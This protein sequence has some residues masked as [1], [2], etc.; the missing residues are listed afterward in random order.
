MKAK[1][2]L[3]SA[4]VLL[5]VLSALGLWQARRGGT[6]RMKTRATPPSSGLASR[7][8]AKTDS[9]DAIHIYQ[10]PEEAPSWSIAYGNEFWR[11][12]DAKPDPIPAQPHPSIDLSDVIER[13]SHALTADRPGTLPTVQART[14]AATVDGAG[15]RFAPYHPPGS[16]AGASAGASSAVR[17]T[18]SE[19]KGKEQRLS[20]LATRTP[21]TPE[22][23]DLLMTGLSALAAE[24]AEAQAIE[25]KSADSQRDGAHR[26]DSGW[27]PQREPETEAAFQTVSVRQENHELY[28]ASASS[29]KWAVLGNTAQA[30][31]DPASGLVEHFECGGQGVAVTWVL[32]R[33]LA[34]QGPLVVEARLTG[35]AYAGQTPAGHHFADRTGTAR[36]RVGN[37]TVIDAAGATW[38]VGMQ[39]RDDSLRITVPS[40]ILAQASYPLAIDPLVAPEF[41]MDTPIVVPAPAAQQNPAVAANA[42]NFFVAWEDQRSA[43]AAGA[44]IFG[45]R[46]T[47][48]GIISDPNGIAISP[49]GA[50]TP[51]V[52]ANG[53]G[54]LVV[55]ADGRN[56]ATKGIDIFGARVNSAGRVVDAG[57]LP[58]CTAAGDQLSPA[59]TADGSDSFVVWQD[60]RNV[61][62]AP[63]IYGARVT[64]GGVVSDPNG[65]PISATLGVQATPAVAFNGTNFLV[66]WA[67]QRGIGD[68][69]TY[70]ARVSKTGQVLETAGIPISTVA[71]GEFF[72]KVAAK[73]TNFLVVWEEHRNA[74][75]GFVDIY[76]AR[77]SGAGMVLDRGGFP[78]GSGSGDRFTPTVAAGLTDYLVVW[79]DSRNLGT[80]GQDIYGARV[81][82]GGVVSDAS[83]IPISTAANDEST[84]VLSFNGSQY[85]VA[86]SDQRNFD[87]TDFDVYGAFVTAAGKVATAAGFAISTGSSD[88]QRPAVAANG[89]SYL[90]VWQDYRNS[91]TSGADLYG[92]RVSAAGAVLD[93]SAIPISTAAAD[94]VMP[95]V[96]ARRGDYLVVW[97]DYRNAGTTGA[98]IYG[99]LVTTAGVVLNPGGIGIGVANADQLA[100]AVAGA[101]TNYLVVWHD[102]R[103][104]A[105]S[106]LDI[107]GSRV[108][109]SAA[110]QD[111]SGLALCTVPGA[112]YGAAVAFNGTNF[113]VV[114]S[115]ERNLGVTGVDV[116]GRRVTPA[117]ALLDSPNIAITQ[118]AGDDL[119]ASISSAGGAF[120]VAWDSGRNAGTTENDIYGARV[121]G[122][123]VVSDPGGIPIG[124]AA[125]FQST[126]AVA[127]SGTNYLVVWQDARNAGASGVDIYGARVG[128][129]GS[130]L[131]TS[132]LAINLGPSDQQYPKLA[133]GS[134]RVFLVACQSLE[135]GSRRSVGN[136][137]YLDDFPVIT[138]IGVS[139]ST[140]TLT[141]LSLS[142]RTYRVEF[143]PK[144]TAPV[145]S[146]LTPDIIATGPAATQ[147]DNTLGAALMRFY[148]VVLLP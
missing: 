72:P 47:G 119:F 1:T 78:V 23:E 31:L 93:P 118:A 106:G 97:E 77:V 62:T 32:P 116:Y 122:A 57:G 36:L 13:V 63:D 79:Q 92:V 42:G 44:G 80:S 103:N 34:D 142:N 83:G 10:H 41:G 45:T 104:L 22:E 105:S 139:G 49:A 51:A 136:F 107:Y 128:T 144:L 94:Q 69:D 6:E 58:I 3:W 71:G 95:A 102:G 135:G 134:P 87:T 125:D 30:L 14:Y 28:A 88:E 56:A 74:D 101:G 17:N 75:T 145:W 138:H 5:V 132:G 54:F 61:D 126:P 46:V 11:R 26:P 40:V 141:W 12:R 55:W 114:W 52:A 33:P 148:R 81:T 108:S 112:Q 38:Q 85:L 59:A 9:A 68:F 133:S 130:V 110:V 39:V 129:D 143:K 86:W 111:S 113:L 64:S 98:D 137:V 65:I 48:T 117:G 91:A 7:N 66:V 84:P 109:S 123:G 37:V 50:A 90:V 60:G 20:A 82:T 124:V 76:A 89:S 24:E 25:K 27:R 131:D 96:A 70:G 35:L 146:N 18:G 127:A 19:S 121:T 115:D 67:D 53:T 140:A 16:G 2:I 120:L 29:L 21:E 4:L 15:L 8:A 99:T 147:V 100:P 43:G 73:G